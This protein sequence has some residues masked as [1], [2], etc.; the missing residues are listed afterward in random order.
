MMT[1]SFAA[2]MPTAADDQLIERVGTAL[3]DMAKAKWDLAWSRFINQMLGALD[4]IEQKSTSSEKLMYIIS[5]LKITLSS[6]YGDHSDWYEDTYS[7][8]IRFS[9]EV[10][11]GMIQK[12]DINLVDYLDLTHPKVV[13]YASKWE[14]EVYT[15]DLVSSNPIKQSDLTKAASCDQYGFSDCIN[16]VTKNGKIIFY[17]APALESIA[18][19]TFKRVNWFGSLYRFT[20]KWVLFSYDM[21]EGV[22]CGGWTSTFFTYFNFDEKKLFYS[23]FNESTRWVSPIPDDDMCQS[24]DT[25]RTTTQT[26][27]FFDSPDVANR[28]PLNINA[29]STEEAF[30]QYYQ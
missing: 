28:K 23:E 7:F 17:S 4:R 2:Y 12:R 15:V 22:P 3:T 24:N 19:R 27:Q 29:T 21:G 18:P 1:S 9:H 10:I 13:K 20:D 26:L 5:E 6:I 11:N 16:I 30:Y 14:Y 8:W 25:K